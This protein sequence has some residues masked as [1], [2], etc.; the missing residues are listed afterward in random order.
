MGEG[1]GVQPVAAPDRCASGA[2][3]HDI[4]TRRTLKQQH[5]PG[6]IQKLQIPAL[7]ITL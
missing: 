2:H 3:L 7:P 1:V 5:A 6:Q 4:T